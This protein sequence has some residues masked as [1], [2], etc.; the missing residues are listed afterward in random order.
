MQM[1]SG[2]YREEP[3]WSYYNQESDDQPG[4]A[5][6]VKTR[7]LDSLGRGNILRSLNGLGSEWG[8]DKGSNWRIG[9]LGSPKRGGG[10]DS[11]G[12]GNILRRVN[13]DDEISNFIH[14]LG[15]VEG[16]NAFLRSLDSLG[17]GNIL[18][19]SVRTIS[20]TQQQQVKE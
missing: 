12:R 14:S 10:L 16:R 9:T 2:A 20:S 6:V 18:K 8:A 13:Y 7:A 19:R 3:Y 5:F 15:P 4:G 17:K 11:L 1:S